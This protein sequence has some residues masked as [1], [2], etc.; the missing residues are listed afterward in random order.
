VL[1]ARALPGARPTAKALPTDPIEANEPMDPM[2][3]AEPIDPTDSH[4]AAEPTLVDEAN[5]S[6][7]RWLNADPQLRSERKER[8]AR[9][10][11]HRRSAMAS[12]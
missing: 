8:V 10:P 4:E 12:R 1:R 9:S 11:P 6:S 5:D 7:D 2:D 3:A